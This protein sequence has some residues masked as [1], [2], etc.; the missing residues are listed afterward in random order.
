MSTAA[1]TRIVSSLVVLMVSSLA[2]P[3]VSFAFFSTRFLFNSAGCISLSVVST[4]CVLCAFFSPRA[5]IFSFYSIYVCILTSSLAVFI[6]LISNCA[7]L[8][9]L[10][11]DNQGI[12]YGASGS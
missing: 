7:L 4:L 11:V 9:R 6:P 8:S 2:L 10:I 3:E 1:H 12:S 5:S